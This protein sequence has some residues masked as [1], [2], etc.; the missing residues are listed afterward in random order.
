MKQGIKNVI[1]ILSAPLALLAAYL[2]VLL[3]W[4]ALGLPKEDVLIET[5]KNW[6][7]HFGLWVVFVSAIL[8]GTLILGQYYP[9]GLVIFLGVI[10]AGH[11]IPKIIQVVAVVSLAF[12]IGYSIDYLIGRYGWYKLFL[13]FGLKKSL[14]KAQDK[15]QKHELSAVIFSYWEPNLAS[16]TATA[17]GIL[18]VPLVKFSLHSAAGIIIWNAFWGTLVASLGAKALQLIGLKWIL[19]I[20]SAWVIIL[21]VKHYA[22]DKRGP[23]QLPL[24]IP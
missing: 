7:D 24:D 15:L 9:G 22:F 10:A 3:L 19:I 1:K 5:T 18:Q 4:R 21:L 8:E 12:L 14:D 16:I 23:K 11:D 13:K 17:A 2:F 6:F 20:F